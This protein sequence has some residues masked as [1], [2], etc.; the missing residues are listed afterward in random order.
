MQTFSRVF[1]SFV[2]FSLAVL[3]AALFSCVWCILWFLP[4]MQFF[5]RVFP[6]FVVSFPGCPAR[7]TV[8]VCLVYFVVSFLG[9]PARSAYLSIL[10][11]FV[12]QA[13]ACWSICF[14]L[15]CAP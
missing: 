14:C 11:L 2:V 1:P 10:I 13:I 15:S 6:S 4:H 9:H 8:F 12:M 3:C 7:S 5:S